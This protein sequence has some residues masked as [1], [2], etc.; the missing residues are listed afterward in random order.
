M[1]NN[2]YSTTIFSIPTNEELKNNIVTLP[3]ILG[4]MVTPQV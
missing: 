1:N 3:Y 2:N 4:A